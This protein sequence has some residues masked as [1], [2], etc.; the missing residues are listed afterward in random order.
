[1]NTVLAVII[2]AATPFFT[3]EES[4]DIERT[5]PTTPT[6]KIELKGFNGSKIEFKSWD[7]NEVS[8]KLSVTISASNGEFEKE[9]IKS[10]NVTEKSSPSVITIRFDEPEA[11]SSGGFFQRLFSFGSSYIRKEIRGEIYIPKTNA[12]YSDMKYGSMT[13]EDMKGPLDLDGQSN[14]LE[15]RNCVSVRMVR[16]DYGKATL[17]NCGGTLSLECQSGTVKIEGFK[18]TVDLLAKYS[19]ITV[20]R[21]SDSTT[22]ESQSGT[23]AID[24][25]QGN[26][27]VN[28][29]YSTLTINKVAGFVDV[30]NKSGK[31]K[32]KSVDGVRVDGL[33]SGIEISSVSGK[34]NRTIDIKGQSGRLDLVDVVGNVNIEN[35]YSTMTLRN[36]RGHVNLESQSARIDAN[37]ITG[38]WKSTTPYSTLTIF[39][40][41][42]QNIQIRN[43]SNPVEIE[44]ASKP[45]DVEI[46][47]E[48][49]SVALTLPTG[50]AGSVRLKATY[51]KVKSN[52]PIEIEDMGSG[53]LALGKMGSG[54]G[55]MRVETTSGD[56]KVT[57]K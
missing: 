30:T 16:N 18:G 4:R 3:N 20:S 40:L 31:I 12:F 28:S 11:R 2:V 19:T 6:Q 15:L 54:G 53:A 29:D 37:N 25:I 13:L 50:F 36:I 43:Q 9:Y 33:Y 8:I 52:L 7:K 38:N 46:L 1:M 49:G 42:A 55:S 56:I 48:Y 23:L 10:V 24:D 47:N 35:P 17:I 27:T 57:Q 39:G 44:L 51:G 21:V 14:T 32:I 22:I 5:I 45:T 26:L 41:T 34:S